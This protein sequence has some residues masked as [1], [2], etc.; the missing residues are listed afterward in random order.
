MKIGTSSTKG[1][2]NLNGRYVVSVL[3]DTFFCL[4]PSVPPV[5][6]SIACFLDGIDENHYFFST[7]SK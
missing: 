5:I 3:S 4:N 2:V 6:P 1:R 7:F